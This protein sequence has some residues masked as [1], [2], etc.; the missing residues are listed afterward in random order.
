MVV[1]GEVP[2]PIVGGGRLVLPLR[3]PMARTMREGYAGGRAPPAEGEV[4]CPCVGLQVVTPKD[5]AVSEALFCPDLPRDRDMRSVLMG[6]YNSLG[7]EDFMAFPWVSQEPPFVVYPR[8]EG[9]GS[10][11]QQRVQDTGAV[12]MAEML[13]GNAVCGFRLQSYCMPYT[14]P[15]MMGSMV[16]EGPGAPMKE[17]AEAFDEFLLQFKLLVQR[18]SG[19][20]VDFYRRPVVTQEVVIKAEKG[21]E[22]DCSLEIAVPETVDMESVI[23]AGLE[24]GLPD[25]LKVKKTWSHR[26]HKVTVLRVMVAEGFQ[27]RQA[28]LAAESLSFK[29]TEGTLVIVGKGCLA[30]KILDNEVGPSMKQSDFRRD[31]STG[32]YFVSPAS[33]MVEEFHR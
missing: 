19:G 14:A 9:Q 5:A 13:S 29:S 20:Q 32:A 27:G 10:D 12:S 31:E 1:E 28:W 7:W 15:E 17:H 18:S 16:V 6:L 25:V 26:G 23:M 3:M 8:Y 2:P 30:V 33:A 4:A 22:R 11:W 24:R 21:G